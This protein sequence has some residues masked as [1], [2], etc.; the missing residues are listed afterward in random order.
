MLSEWLMALHDPG[1]NIGKGARN[2]YDFG[3]SLGDV[4]NKIENML[5][6]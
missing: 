2:G 4:G 6:K 3:N 1:D 5:E